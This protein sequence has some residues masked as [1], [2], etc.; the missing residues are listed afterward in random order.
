MTPRTNIGRLATTTLLGVAALSLALAAPAAAQFSETY[1]FIKAVKDKDPAKATSIL[2]APGNTIINTRD[3]DTGDAAI[4]I[5]VRRSDMAWLGFLLQHGADPNIR[6][7]AGNTP[8]LLATV[9][10][11]TEAVHVLLLVRARVDMKNNI[12]ETP[13]IKAVQLRNVA[14]AKQLLEAGA[15]PDLADSAAGYSARD[16]AQQDSRGGPLAKLLK[17][18]PRHKPAAVQGPQP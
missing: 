2:D 8:L 11:F 10:S 15:D 16:Y 13:L 5:V 12:G 1:N 18:T 17:E 7:R 4:H 14:V 3:G 6:D 9:S